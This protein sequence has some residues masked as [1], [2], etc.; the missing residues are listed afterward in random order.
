[1]AVYTLSRAIDFAFYSEIDISKLIEER[2][3]EEREKAENTEN[4]ENDA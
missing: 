4:I 2:A 1:M 3:R